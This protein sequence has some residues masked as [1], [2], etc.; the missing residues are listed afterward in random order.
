MAVDGKVQAVAMV[1]DGKVQGVV[2]VV[3][4]DALRM[5]VAKGEAEEVVGVVL[6]IV[7]EVVVA[8][9][10]VG[11]VMVVVVNRLVEEVSGQEGVAVVR[12]GGGDGGG[13][14]GEY[15]GGGGDGG[16]GEYTGGG[17]DGGGGGGDNTGG[18]RA[19]GGE[20]IDG[21]KGL[22]LKEP[23]FTEGVAL[24]WAA[25]RCSGLAGKQF[26]L[27]SKAGRA[28][29]LVRFFNNP[30][31]AGKQERKPLFI[32][33]ISFSLDMFPMLEGTQPWNLLFAKTIT[34]TGEFP[35][36]SGK[37]KTKRL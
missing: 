31:S 18:G 14:G 23:Q 7:E 22:H 19:T 26:F 3:V 12:G 24:H 27:S 16:G 28:K 9:Y 6:Y 11:A 2:M 37:S 36:L 29:H 20:G 25:E 35:K 30:T 32:R 4:V 33:I 34:D 1:V 13:G 10:M 15:T 8:L 5:V 21:T 17:G